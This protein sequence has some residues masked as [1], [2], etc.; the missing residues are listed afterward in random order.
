MHER[1]G[2]DVNEN[3]LLQTD[4]FE[5]RSQMPEEH[6]YALL[7]TI[8]HAIMAG[9]KRSRNSTSGNDPIYPEV[10]LAMGLRFTGIIITVF[11]LSDLYGMSESSV[12]RYINMFFNVVDFNTDLAEIIE[13]NLV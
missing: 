11:D 6:V 12:K 10:V 9:F 13:R 1:K 7:D 4:A 2:W 5:Q 8:R 3:M